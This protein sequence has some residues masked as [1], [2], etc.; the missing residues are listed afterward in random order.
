LSD[1]YY[2]NV[3]Y[4]RGTP[5]GQ[6]PGCGVGGG[7]LGRARDRRRRQRLAAAGNGSGRR[8]VARSRARSAA[9]GGSGNRIYKEEQRKT[10]DATRRAN[11]EAEGSPDVAAQH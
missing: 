11:E 2:L 1:L 9:G 7:Q 3:Y 4:S 5:D 8:A 6:R 10:R